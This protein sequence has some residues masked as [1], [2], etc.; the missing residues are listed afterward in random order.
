ML[1]SPFAT[2]STCSI[3][4]SIHD[5]TAYSITPHDMITMLEYSSRHDKTKKAKKKPSTSMMVRNF[6]HRCPRKERL[7]GEA[8]QAATLNIESEISSSS[9]D[10]DN[11]NGGTK[12]SG[13]DAVRIMKH[14]RTKRGF[15]QF[16]VICWDSRPIWLK[17][18]EMKKYAVENLALYLQNQNVSDSDS[19]NNSGK[20]SS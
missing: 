4:N 7:D 20:M 5:T 14:R 8:A 11:G 12:H 18:P 15:H 13:I 1:Q 16:E 3:F 2:L 10:E 17:R 6:M 19:D 9:P